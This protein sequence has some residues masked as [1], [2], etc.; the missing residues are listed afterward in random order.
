MA[1]AQVAGLIASYGAGGLTSISLFSSTFANNTATIT[2]PGSLQAGDAA[3]LMDGSVTFGAQTAIFPAGFTTIVNASTGAGTEPRS[4]VSSR[5]LDG[6]E[7]GTITGMTGLSSGKLLLIFRGNIPITSV[8]PST[9]NSE[10]TS[11]NPSSQVVSA[12]TTPGVVF[13]FAFAGS[14]FSTASPAFDATQAFA[15]SGSDAIGGYKIYNSSP[16]AHTIDMN[17][18]GSNILISGSLS[19]A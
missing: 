17:D 18:F 12:P 2:W 19:F 1:G 7:S 4:I 11:G 5:V 9:W 10:A 16:A 8:T 15:G 6:S 14:S 3:V 13:G